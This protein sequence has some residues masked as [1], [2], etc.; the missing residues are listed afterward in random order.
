MSIEFTFDADRH[1]YLV[2]GRLVP[3]VTQVLQ[4]TGLGADYSIVPPEVLERKRIIGQ[5]VHEATQ[6]LDEGSLDLA[7]IAKVLRPK[8]THERPRATTHPSQAR[9]SDPGNGKM[10]KLR[11]GLGSARSGIERNDLC[12]LQ[13]RKRRFGGAALTVQ[14]KP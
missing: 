13:L 5:F 1:L 9:E 14:R 10:F 12:P 6:Y 8:G 4:A 7:S 11:D 3:S 2:Q